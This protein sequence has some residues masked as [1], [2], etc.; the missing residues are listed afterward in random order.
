[1]LD[2]MRKA[3]Q[4]PIGKVVMAVLMGLLIVSFAVWG[5]GDMLHGFTP[6]TVATVGSAKI[7]K[8][9]YSNQLQT[10]LYRLQRQLRRSLTPQQARAMGLDAQVL[11]RMID[12]AA[13]DESARKMGLAIS[14]QTIAQAVRDDPG[15]KGADGKFDAGKFN[16]YLRDSGLTER[17]FIAQQ[18]DVYLRQQ[19][20]YSLVDGLSPPKALVQA[21]LDA[22]NETRAIAY[23][24]LAPAAAG[25]I[26]PP[27]DATL[28]AF[29]D[30]HKAQWRAPEYRS[31]D[32]LVVTPA[33][34]AKPDSV[35]DE[36]A[37]AEYE[38]DKAAKYTVP[39]KRKLQQIVFPSEAE[40]A[41][42]DAKIKAGTSFE[43]IAKARN[44]ADADLNLGEVT[45]AGVFD[46]A[47]ADAA[48]ALPQGAVSTPIKG[49]FG[50]AL[51]KV[52][53]ITPGSVKPFDAVKGAIK[54]DI[55]TARAVDQVQSLHDKIEDARGNGKSVAEAA[56]GFGL[57]T[58]S[59]DSVGLD[60]LN[61][62][63][64][65][66][67][68]V[69]SALVLPAVFASDIG[70]DDEPIPTKDHG[71]AW[72]SV[73]KIDPA[74]D[75][76]FEEVKD[77]VTAVWRAE[78]TDKRLAEDAAQTVKKLDAGADIAE[79]AKAANAELKTAKDIRR[80]SGGGLPAD[81]TS[82]VFTVGPSG[83]GSA[84]T[85]AG[86]LVFKV[87]SDAI[88]PA[89]PGD[90]AVMTTEQRLKSEIASSLVQQY[91][92]ALKRD[93]G[94]TVDRSLMQGAEGG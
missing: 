28:K 35:T 6:D 21:L 63:G 31:F 60:D 19:L 79:L 57:A 14:D 41:E 12:N 38:K 77:K 76:T 16:E 42:A 70:V 7:S 87:T 65:K 54:Q 18:R 9:E 44:L 59:F 78:E 80:S 26:P 90:P 62:A 89:E 33:T 27:S 52:E 93:L 56:K 94:V 45:K 72:F 69:A 91:V 55:A 81:V 32:E 88:P 3:T 82:A 75:R 66:A 48:F 50:F 74:H 25:D 43:A 67:N 17:G 64:A 34:L 11:G 85:P 24:T 53:S 71:Y 68:V 13:Y 47:V 23:F 29:F 2:G 46:P 39:E 22:Q 30:A 49:R 92:D 86:R 20:Q 36:D 40:A 4:G 1:M 37:R 61:A 84:T 83:A 73:T 51:V 15:L 58:T 10:E 5:V 8:E